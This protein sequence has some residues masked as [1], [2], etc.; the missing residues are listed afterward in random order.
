MRSRW[1]PPLPRRGRAP[2]ACP[3]R[4]GAAFRERRRGAAAPVPA[5]GAGPDCG[6]PS[7]DTAARACGAPPSP[8]PPPSPPARGAPRPR[9]RAPAPPTTPLKS[10][11][12][13][14]APPRRAPLN[15]MDA[16][17]LKVSRAFQVCV[18]VHVH[19]RMGVASLAGSGRLPQHAPQTTPATGLGTAGSAEPATRARRRR[20]AWQGCCWAPGRARSHAPPTHLYVPT[21]SFIICQPPLARHHHRRRPQAQQSDSDEDE[22][23]GNG[24]SGSG[25]SDADG[26]GSGEEGSAE[27]VRKR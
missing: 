26:S 3:G 24:G 15:P 6:P 27:E 25:S 2:A 9:A 13:P 17:I 1:R 21:T 16:I 7:L 23:D 12:S 20:T 8:L 19:A 4:C 18:H 5:L 22:E 14:A 10:G 11:A